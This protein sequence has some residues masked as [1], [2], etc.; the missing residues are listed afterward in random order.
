MFSADQEDITW[1]VNHDQ[2]FLSAPVYNQSLT[3]TCFRSLPS[4]IKLMPVMLSKDFC[5]GP[6]EAE[7]NGF[8]QDFASS[9]N[10]DRAAPI[11]AGLISQLVT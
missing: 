1:G 4:S 7:Y 5:I 6:A 9:K 8:S 3:E 10:K 2:P 11:R